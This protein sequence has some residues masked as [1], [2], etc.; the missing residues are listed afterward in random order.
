MAATRE[1][2]ALLLGFLLAA[3]LHIFVLSLFYLF[4][5][6]VAIFYISVEST[7]SLMSYVAPILAI[8]TK[9]PLAFDFI[10]EYFSAEHLD[11][12]SIFWR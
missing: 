10:L 11:L 9:F 6:Y 5:S 4:M 3:E 8:P 2:V 12:I 7:P 1:G